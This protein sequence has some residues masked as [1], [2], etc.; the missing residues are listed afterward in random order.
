MSFLD[1]YF[2][3]DINYYN[4]YFGTGQSQYKYV[5][6]YIGNKELELFSS[7]DNNYIDISTPPDVTGDKIIKFIVNASQ[8]FYLIF[9]NSDSDYI[10]F[11]YFNGEI[12][13]GYKT[14]GGGE[15]RY[16]IL[17]TIESGIHEIVIYKT[18]GN[19][20]KLLID[21]EEISLGSP[22]TFS[23]S[24]SNNNRIGNDGVNQSSGSSIFDVEI[25]DNIWN[26]IHYWRGYGDNPWN[27]IVSGYNGIIQGA[28]G[29]I[30]VE[31][32][33][34][35]ILKVN[36]ASWNKLS[37]NYERNDVYQSILRNYTL[38]FQFKKSEYAGGNFI[39]NAYET[40]GI[41]KEINCSIYE[42][43]PQT[44]DYE[45]LYTCI[46]D[47][48]PG[49]FTIERDFI[50]IGFIDGSKE[51]KLKIREDIEY[52]IFNTVS[53]DGVAIDSFN[54]QPADI[55]YNSIDIILEVESELT[56]DGG[57][58]GDLKRLRNGS[59]LDP[60]DFTPKFIYPFAKEITKN[61]IN[62][63]LI[64]TKSKNRLLYEN[65]N[66]FPIRIEFNDT[67]I[68]NQSNL[69][70]VGAIG[71]T[72][73][74]FIN[75]FHVSVTVRFI[76]IDSEDN[77]ITY[78]ELDNYDLS[79]TVSEA[80]I[81]PTPKVYNYNMSFITPIDIQL[82]SGWKL[83]CEIIY[84]ALE[85]SNWFGANLYADLVS[86]IDFNFDIYENSESLVGDT[87]SKAV[88]PFEAFTRLIQL[89][90][91]ETDTDKILDS[92]VFGRIDSEFITYSENGEASRDVIFNGYMVRGFPSP[93]LKL[94]IKN[95]FNQFSFMYGLGL[96]YDR[97]NERFYIEYLEEFYDTSYFMF[98]LGEVSEFTRELNS[99]SYFNTIQGGI[100]NV[101]YEE[102]QGINEYNRNS[103]YSLTVP[104]KENINIRPDY[105]TDSIQIELARRKP[106]DGN[107]AEDT[108]YDEN[109][110]IV[111][112]DN[113]ETVQN[114][115]SV[116][117][118]PGIENYYNIALTPR[119]CAI[120][121][122]NRI[123]TALDKSDEDV[124]FVSGSGVNIGYNNQNGDTVNEH[125]DIS[126]SEITK[127][128]LFTGEL[129]KF[130]HPVNNSIIQV[131]NNN[132]HGFVRF[133]FEGVTYEMYIKLL[134]ID[135]YPQ[136]AEWEGYGKIYYGGDNRVLEDGTN[137][138]FEDNDNHILEG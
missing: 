13:L 32:T 93:Q 46:G 36:A 92:N 120:R 138:I 12:N 97:P 42:R 10:R 78:I 105:Y 59:G 55:T 129:Y 111:R 50:N 86:D 51:N 96:G 49:R 67:S 40:Y 44:N 38:D 57:G 116:T 25:F 100:Q 22:V 104:I 77:D 65:T 102:L 99:D 88:Y 113:N 9:K 71:G 103:N 117:G 7:I 41:F 27:D 3:S 64:V 37:I 5:L 6:D 66:E 70:R 31:D 62:D 63:R 131:L 110:M 16:E 23:P 87:T 135:D 28:S 112:T 107:S 53:T 20:T 95:L 58:A 108:Q 74:T 132:P 91:S 128:A 61:D 8:V 48:K 76:I 33:F 90:T 14:T 89:S 24:F 26:R 109:I 68:N 114:G 45:L 34:M 43:N 18:T 35:E 83:G 126:Q 124:K 30:I 21:N 15:T 119:E 19:V 121:N 130:K 137:K 82:Q 94:S 133:S 127:S 123:L 17:E 79:D 106:F 72:G 4:A 56:V 52:N 125:D 2:Y 134:Q 101:E 118:F 81:Y 11:G 60:S 98:D 69:I 73:S 122:G 54:N 84:E 29:Q 75:Y 1:T 85:Q 115:S 47:F 136:L 39:L 80:E